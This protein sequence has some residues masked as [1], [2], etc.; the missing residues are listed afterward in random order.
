QTF[1]A[2]YSKA[3]PGD[4][5]SLAGSARRWDVTVGDLDFVIASA[6]PATSLNAIAALPI[7][8]S[9]EKTTDRAMRLSLAGGSE[10]DVFV[11]DPA[12]W[13]SALVRATGNARHLERLGRIPEHAATEE[14]VYAANGLPWIPP[15]L[16]TGTEEFDRWPE[17]PSLVTLNDIN[18]EFHA[19]TTWSDGGA[20]IREMAVAAASRGYAYLGITDHSHSL[21]VA[22]GLDVER[23]IAQRKELAEADG[24]DGVKLLAGA[25]VEVLRDGTLDYDDET[26]AQLDVVVASLHTGLRQP[27]RELT[28]RL[29][30]VLE[31]PN[32][33]IIAHPSGRLIERREGGNFDWNQVFE[34]A[35][36][37]GT[38]LEI[39]ADPARLDLDPHLAR[40]A[41]AAGC[42]ITVNCDAHSPGGFAV[43]EY[44]VA[45]ARRAWLTPEQIFNCRP[46]NQVLDWLAS[47]AKSR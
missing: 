32:V 30:R 16:R 18:G 46:R 34:T 10:A 12:S 39:N 26:L 17:I 11:A 35:A 27:Q 1:V 38:A 41:S 5:I 45:M 4:T 6:D 42:L 43:M 19:H 20:S 37:T 7:V 33:D 14:E 15:E 24:I 44:G 29:L 2:L 9:S 8:T 21:G 23:L 47:R 28:D 13:G 36:R 25:E 3:R 40:R 22:G 31:N